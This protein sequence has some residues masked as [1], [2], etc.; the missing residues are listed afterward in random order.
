MNKA[1]EVQVMIMMIGV[2]G[3]KDTAVITH[4][5]FHRGGAVKSHFTGTCQ[6]KKKSFVRTITLN[7][8]GVRPQVEFPIDLEKLVLYI[9]RDN[10]LTICKYRRNVSLFFLDKHQQALFR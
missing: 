3:H 1:K 5:C 4:K 6:R 8:V 2:V 10:L 9:H 7:Y